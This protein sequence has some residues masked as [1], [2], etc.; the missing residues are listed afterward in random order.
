MIVPED[1]A[2]VRIRGLAHAFGTG[3]AAKTVL[4]DIDL[5]LTPGQIVIMTGPS[6]SG[7]TT[8]LT[9]IGALR[10]VQQGSL[11]VMGTE[12]NGLGPA[13]RVGVRRSI[14]FI[15]QAHNLF[16]A[17]TAWQN[18]LLALDLFEHDRATRRARADEILGLLGL[19]Q[20]AD[21]KPAALS[22]GQRQR[23]AIARAL[24]N[25]PRLILADEP[26]AALDW[27][28]SRDVIEI[29]Q[30]RASARGAAIVLVTHDNRILDVAD[31]I[32]NLVDG[33]IVS[34]VHARE[35][36]VICEFLARCPVFSGLM[37]A[38]L[39]D[40]AGK[41]GRERHDAGAAM[42]RQGAAGDKFYLIRS[43]RVSVRQESGAGRAELATLGEGEFFGERALVT[44]EPRNATVVAAGPV[45]LYTLGKE[46]FR[47]ALDASPTFKE[48]LLKVFFNRTR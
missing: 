6:G 16:D 8:L 19:A 36:A 38:T 2:L 44:G 22:G 3:D 20:S 9:L 4:A 41:M 39:S 43:G 18:V 15:F 10:S 7:K 42:I 13:E 40:I 35:A 14:G 31:R 37:P 5:D 32:V 23:V 21:H 33:R 11:R 48:E 1:G 34:D 47:A 26:T 24:V 45:E 30:N 12:L 29:L 17:L 28:A 27:D 25:E 46:E